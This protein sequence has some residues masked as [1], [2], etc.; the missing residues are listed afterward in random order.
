MPNSL[1]DIINRLD[2]RI[3]SLDDLLKAEKGKIHPVRNTRGVGTNGAA[4][5]NG[6][7]AG[8]AAANNGRAAAG[9][10]AANAAGNAGAN[11]GRAAVAPAGNTAATGNNYPNSQVNVGNLIRP[12]FVINPDCITDKNAAAERHLG[13]PIA[14]YKTKAGEFC[15]YK[16]D[17]KRKWFDKSG[18]ER[19][20]PKNS[21]YNRNTRTY[22]QAKK[23]N[24]RRGPNAAAAAVGGRTRNTRRY[25]RSKRSSL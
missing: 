24:T 8:N 2:G 1:T 13:K 15:V 25:N 14:L 10:A 6:R 4:G 11:N 7:A 18:A 23:N 22:S 5:N 16:E 9:N 20:L 12:N 17:R 19:V 21:S 3:D